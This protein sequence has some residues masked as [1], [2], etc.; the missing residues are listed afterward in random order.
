MTLPDVIVT[1]LI[2]EQTA[3]LTLF[4]GHNVIRGFWIRQLSIL[5]M[6]GDSWLC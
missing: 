5:T 6:D 2:R 4:H 3:L 1:V